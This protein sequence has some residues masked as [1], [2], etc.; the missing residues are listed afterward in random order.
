MIEMAMSIFILAAAI[1]L[2]IV[3]VGSYWKGYNND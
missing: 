3:A 1:S 2:I